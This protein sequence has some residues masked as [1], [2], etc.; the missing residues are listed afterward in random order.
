MLIYSN[1]EVMD[2]DADVAD[3]ESSSVVHSLHFVLL[4]QLLLVLSPSGVHL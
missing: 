2:V 1:D 4:E 3:E